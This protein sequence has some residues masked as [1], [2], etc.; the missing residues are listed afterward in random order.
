[1]KLLPSTAEETQGPR[2]G[3]ENCPLIKSPKGCCVEVARLKGSVRPP[4]SGRQSGRL[5]ALLHATGAGDTSFSWRAEFR[6]RSSSAALSRKSLGALRNFHPLFQRFDRLSRGERAL[7]ELDALGN[8]R[9]LSVDVQP[10][11]GIECD[12][13]NN[14]I[15]T[16]ARQHLP[17][18]DSVVFCVTSFQLL[19]LAPGKVKI[20]RVHSGPTELAIA[21][22]YGLRNSHSAQ[23]VNALSVYHQRVFD[24]EALQC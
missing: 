10:G 7:G 6:I 4:T 16:S 13:V 12:H 22:L 2:K 20:Q 15:R 11:S 5:N 17:H 14:C 21:Y 1:M 8:A 18:H 19:D 9:R 24:A 3:G 23:L